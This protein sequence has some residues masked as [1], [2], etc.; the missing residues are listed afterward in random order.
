MPVAADTGYIQKL[1]KSIKLDHSLTIAIAAVY[2]LKV[3][4]IISS[5]VVSGS[6][7]IF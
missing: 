1:Y 6:S 5:R 4:P 2:S 7:V 3:L